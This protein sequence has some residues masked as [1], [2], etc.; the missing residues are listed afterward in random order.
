MA[1]TNFVLTPQA[2]RLCAYIM[3][4]HTL[5]GACLAFLRVTVLGPVKSSLETTSYPMRHKEHRA[6]PAKRCFSTFPFGTG[7]CR[8]THL[9]PKYLP[10]WPASCLTRAPEF[11][12]QAGLDGLR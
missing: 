2:L 8:V 6:W 11:P 5:V 4:L 7:V 3:T 10:I 1:L 12:P 9:W